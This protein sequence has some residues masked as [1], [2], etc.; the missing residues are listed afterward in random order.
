M[1]LIRKKI[2]FLFEILKIYFE[3]NWV[4]LYDIVN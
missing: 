2:V 3:W 4:E 1:K